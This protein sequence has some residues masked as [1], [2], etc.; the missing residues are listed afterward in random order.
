MWSE[1]IFPVY[2]VMKEKDKY[3]IVTEYGAQVFLTKKEFKKFR[4]P[5]K[6]LFEKLEKACVIITKNNINKVIH[7]Y[8]KRFF[9]GK[10]PENHVII[11]NPSDKVVKY[12]RNFAKKISKKSEVKIK[13]TAST[14]K[15]KICSGIL[16]K[17]AYDEKGYIYP[18]EEAVGIE[19]FKIGN[20]FK[21]P[22]LN[23]EAVKNFLVFSIFNPLCVTCSKQAFCTPCPVKIFKKYGRLGIIEKK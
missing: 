15:D 4:F 10:K 13:K 2:F 11:G 20:V 7:F 19:I 22:A 8:K 5:D 12:V 16:L 14:C 1:F 9:I 3:I 23:K 17:L 18:C 21:K 6:K